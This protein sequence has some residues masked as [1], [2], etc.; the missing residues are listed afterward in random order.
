[1]LSG[2]VRISFWWSNCKS[3][4]TGIAARSRC[5]RDEEE[6]LVGPAESA[7]TCVVD[8]RAGVVQEFPIR[9][10]SPQEMTT[11]LEVIL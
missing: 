11:G 10:A 5:G 7:L 4:M 9:G 6:G 3:V 2:L 8:T 1:V